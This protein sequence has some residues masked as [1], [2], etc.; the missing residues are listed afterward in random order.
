MQHWKKPTGTVVSLDEGNNSLLASLCRLRNQRF[1][2]SNGYMIHIAKVDDIFAHDNPTCTVFSGICTLQAL[3]LG[4][5]VLVQMLFVTG[6]DDR[7]MPQWHCKV[8]ES[9]KLHDASSISFTNQVYPSKSWGNSTFQ[10]SVLKKNI[11][12][13]LLPQLTVK[14]ARPAHDL[15]IF[16]DQVHQLQVDACVADNLCSLQ[17]KRIAMMRIGPAKCAVSRLSFPLLYI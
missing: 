14:S 15:P 6:E 2:C 5:F 1:M 13:L 12:Y 9:H 3:A 17:P 4:A 16:Q 8:V 11:W 10:K 7:L